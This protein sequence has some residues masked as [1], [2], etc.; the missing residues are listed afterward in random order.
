MVRIKRGI[1]RADERKNVCKQNARRRRGCL[2][3]DMA[4]SSEPNT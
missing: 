4:L 2:R 3:N 1:R